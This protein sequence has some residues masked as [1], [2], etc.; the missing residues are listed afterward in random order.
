MVDGLAFALRVVYY[1]GAARERG[2]PGY[3][4]DRLPDILSIQE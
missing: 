4:R 3:D 1:M 2:P